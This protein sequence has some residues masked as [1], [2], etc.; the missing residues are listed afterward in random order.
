MLGMRMACAIVIC[1]FALVA[2]RITRLLGLDFLVLLAFPLPVPLPFL[3]GF[4]TLLLQLFL[5][6]L[7]DFLLLSLAFFLSLFGFLLPPRLFPLLFSGFLL[8]LARCFFFIFAV[9]C[10][11]CEV[12]AIES[13]ILDG[14]LATGTINARLSSARN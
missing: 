9:S 2:R 3:G 1:V 8:V 4:L 13:G 6:F 5:P 10:S 14:V 12:A 7:R 11:G